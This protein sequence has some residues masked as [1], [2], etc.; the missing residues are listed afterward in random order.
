MKVEE[1]TSHLKLVVFYFN[2]FPKVIE[3]VKVCFIEEN[4][5]EI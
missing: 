5:V 1:L 3:K 2:L 4:V